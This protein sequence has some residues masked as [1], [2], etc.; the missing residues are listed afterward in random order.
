[1]DGLAERHRVDRDGHAGTLRVAHGAD[2]AGLVDQLHDHAAVH[3]AERVGVLRQHQLVQRERAICAGRFLRC[4]R[5]MGR[6][7]PRTEA[8]C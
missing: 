7:L 8:A 1:M 6:P 5:V 4:V 2:R 3:V